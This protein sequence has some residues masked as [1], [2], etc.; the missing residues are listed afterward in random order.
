LLAIL[1]IVLLW[2]FACLALGSFFSG[3][4]RYRPREP[5]PPVGPF[6]WRGLGIVLAVLLLIGLIGHLLPH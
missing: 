4:R 3:E 6:P 5:A 1:V 2:F